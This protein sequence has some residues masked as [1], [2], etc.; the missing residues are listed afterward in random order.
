[1]NLEHIDGFDDALRVFKA[2]VGPRYNYLENLEN[3]CN[4]NQYRGLPDWFSIDRPLWERAPCI[5]YLLSKE[6]I[7][8]KV[9]L[10]LGEGRFPE[11]TTSPGEGDPLADDT[12]TEQGNLNKADSALMDAF[13]DR[14]MK[15]SGFNAAAS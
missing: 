3:W 12:E 15:Q 5:T 2:N 1:M 13:I 11:F 14:V 9:D 7:E 4:G 10:V 8:S 6:A